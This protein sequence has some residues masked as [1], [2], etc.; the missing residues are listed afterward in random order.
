MRGG[1]EA[2]WTRRIALDNPW[3]ADGVVPDAALPRRGFF[4]RV[5]G[6][7]DA[8]VWRGPLVVT[9]P[10]RVGKSTLVRQ[11]VARLLDAG[12]PPRRLGWIDLEAPALQGAPLERLAEAL[13]ADLGV[14]VFDSADHRPGWESELAVLAAVRPGVR[15]IAVAAL[16]PPDLPE[17]WAVVVLPPLTFCEYLR[18]TGA[19]RELVEPVFFGRAAAPAMFAVPDVPALNARFLAYLNSGGFPETVLMAPNGDSA[20]ARLRGR[21]L[22]AAL[23]SDLPALA[24]IGSTS[25]LTALFT[26][27]ARNAGGELSVEGIAERTGLAKNT[28][29]R[30]LDHLEA[31]HL[32]VRLPRLHPE[33]ARFQRMRTFRLHLTAPCLHAALF[34]PVAADDPAFAA[35]AA[36]AVVGQWLA[37]PEFPLLHFARIGQ[38]PVDLVS[39]DPATGRPAWAAALP[40]A[41]PDEPAAVAGLIRFAALNAPL[42]WIGATTRAVAALRRYD[43]VEVWR[44]PACQYA[45][46]IGRRVI[47]EAA[48]VRGAGPARAMAQVGQKPSSMI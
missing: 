43:G 40:C 33:G 17:E 20:G 23:R 2:E 46:E 41:D 31:A 44:R 48:K 27:L 45:Y 28:V 24:G 37:S 38:D 9:G 32:I 6:L 3:W 39:L 21:V 16:R 35:L 13:P 22:G 4:E 26:L 25:E 10:R 29:R 12:L 19:E 11:A 42:R 7:L 18:F 5:F 14:V 1:S 36:G 47:D 34:G 30:Y 15:F 8:P